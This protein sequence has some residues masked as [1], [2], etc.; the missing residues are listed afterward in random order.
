M[1]EVVGFLG[2]IPF[3]E[4]YLKALKEYPDA[5]IEISR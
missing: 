3:V 2:K 4:E 5:E 1:T